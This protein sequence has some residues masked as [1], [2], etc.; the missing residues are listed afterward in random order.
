MQVL[1]D[2][3]TNPFFLIVWGVLVILSLI[4]L[5]VD[6]CRN[7]PQLVSLMKWVWFFT[8][9]YSGPIGLAIY[10]LLWA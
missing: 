8:V 5:I 4:I 9:L 3:L 7:N 2:A 10:F 1:T 6:L